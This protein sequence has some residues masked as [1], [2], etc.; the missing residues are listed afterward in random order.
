MPAKGEHKGEGP[1]SSH[2]AVFSR[3]CLTVLTIAHSVRWRLCPRPCVCPAQLTYCI[4]SFRQSENLCIIPQTH[5]I[6]SGVISVNEYENALLRIRL[7]FAVH[8]GTSRQKQL[9]HAWFNAR[10]SNCLL[11]RVLSPTSSQIL[12]S[13]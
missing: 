13:L 1:S 7:L 8:D 2:S 12:I 10:P 4:C 6:K 5:T 11:S 3:N 9:P